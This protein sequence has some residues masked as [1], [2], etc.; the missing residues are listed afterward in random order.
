LVKGWP[1]LI[2]IFFIGEGLAWSYKPLFH[3]WRVDL[4]ERTTVLWK[5]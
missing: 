1:D 3:W 5:L 4:I 2:S